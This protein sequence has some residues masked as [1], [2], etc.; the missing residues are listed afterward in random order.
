M[1]TDI[2]V[3]FLKD[4]KVDF[5]RMENFFSMLFFALVIILVF[6][7][8][9]VADNK[10]QIMIASG[11]FWVTFLLS[12]IVSLSK[13]FQMEK[14]NDCMHALLLSPVSR[15]SIYVGKMAGNI[16]FILLIQLLI[17]PAFN[18]F[19]HVLVFDYFTELITL[20]LLAVIGFS[21]LGTLLAALT[22]DLR[23]KEIL[24]P[25]LLF[26]LIVPL[27]LA[28]VTITQSILTGNGLLGAMNWIKLL[29]GYDLIFFIIAYLTFDFVMEV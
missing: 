22:T 10:S 17:I 13:S 1:F 3:I 23:F 2:W 25:I 8:A 11:V 5:R 20:N 19:F 18:L 12:G 27:L 14:E 4:L 28:C 26:P 15:G 9:L 21:A 24:L 6:A 7:F 16:V 29:I